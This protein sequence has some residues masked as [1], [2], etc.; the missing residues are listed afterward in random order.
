MFID[1]NKNL[2]IPDEYKWV[3]LNNYQFK[4]ALKTILDDDARN[5]F[6]QAKAG[7]GKSLMINIAST[8][9]ENLVVLSTTGT[10]AMQLSTDG[11]PA[12]TIHSFF[13]FNAVP[14]LTEKDI[15]KMFGE[16]KEI[17][18]KMET[19]II[20]EVSMLNAQMFDWIVKKLLYIRRGDL[21]RI[22]LFGD[23]LQLPPVISNERLVQAYFQEKYSGRIM[24]FNSNAY[25]SLN[26]KMLTLNQSYRQ[27]DET[28]ADNIYSIGINSYDDS[29][30]SYFNQRVMTLAK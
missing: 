22:I 20:D 3:D 19:L 15:Y 7:C 9:K 18:K 11:I 30:L 4:T 14:L 16:T 29:I 2:Y 21:P 13:Q 27:K 12:K 10:T 25:K 1:N 17:I 23:V 28:F 26:F 5:I 24:F 8:V 6:I